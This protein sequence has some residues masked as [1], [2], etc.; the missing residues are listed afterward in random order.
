LLYRQI[1]Q[2]DA[3]VEQLREAIELDPRHIA[4]FQE[5]TQT[6]ID[7]E[8]HKDAMMILKQALRLAPDNKVLK[9]QLEALQTLLS[10]GP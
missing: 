10:S 4:A 1:G 6:L 3:A 8:Q 7:L 5:L 9:S 2:L